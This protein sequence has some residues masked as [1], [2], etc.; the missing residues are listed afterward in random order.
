MALREIVI[1]ALA[2]AAVA[3][4]A[5]RY[6]NMQ[7]RNA[8]GASTPYYDLECHL[9]QVSGSVVQQDVAFSFSPYGCSC[10]P[11]LGYAVG[12]GRGG[13]L[14]EEF[15]LDFELGASGDAH[16]HASSSSVDSPGQIVMYSRSNPEETM[17]DIP[18]EGGTEEEQGIR[19]RM[20]S[21]WEG[22]WP[23]FYD[24]A[25]P[26]GGP[27]MDRMMQVCVEDDITH[28]ADLISEEAFIMVE[29]P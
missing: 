14:V 23:A 3:L 15:E 19:A 11:R 1:A 28:Q 10:N 22:L 20:V 24:G 6:Q 26:G 17:Q 7:A 16:V 5:C 18:M 4:P 2:A 9:E 21:M 27:I 25:I 8:D 29:T 12:T 13:G